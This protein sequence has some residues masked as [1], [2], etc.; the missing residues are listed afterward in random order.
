[1]TNQHDFEDPYDRNL[2]NS[3]ER[4]LSGAENTI[5]P[6]DNL[7]FD[8]F[9]DERLFDTEIKD[10]PISE[11]KHSALNLKSSL[12]QRASFASSAASD[13]GE[14]LSDSQ[15][16]KSVRFQFDFDDSGVSTDNNASPLRLKRRYSEPNVRYFSGRSPRDDVVSEGAQ[17]LYSD[18][19][20]DEGLGSDHQIELSPDN[21]VS[22]IVWCLSSS[23]SD[24]SDPKDESN[25]PIN[26]GRVSEIKERFLQ[27]VKG[28]EVKGQ[29]VYSEP[30]QRS[31]SVSKLVSET[32]KQLMESKADA[33]TSVTKPGKLVGL[34][35]EL[36]I[37]MV[38][39]G[40]DSPDADAEFERFEQSRK[41]SAG[42]PFFG[43]PLSLS[44]WQPEGTTDTDEDSD[45]DNALVAPL[46][47]SSIS[48]FRR[49]GSLFTGPMSGHE[50]F[51]KSTPPRTPTSRKNSASRLSCI[52]E[53]SPQNST[54]SLT[55]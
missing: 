8:L 32:T 1:M 39:G 23:Q 51:M 31:R 5:H 12:S 24:S 17:K 43:A 41:C 22:N 37:P 4:L 29:E 45:D 34:D 13:L 53:E 20:G 48:P 3:T 47:A 16:S 55:A 21:K 42:L 18:T 14:E 15:T 25:A 49:G 26:H 40:V 30:R 44:P 28:Q 7:D 52:P 27:E 10:K 9:L 19:E 50:M 36:G 2:S 35:R 54:I 6:P 33:A 38:V 11:H 46:K